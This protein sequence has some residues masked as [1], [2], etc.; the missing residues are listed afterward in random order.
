MMIL[1]KLVD[2]TVLVAEVASYNWNGVIQLGACAEIACAGGR[3]LGQLAAE[4]P[5]LAT[6]IVPE[7]AGGAVNPDHVI[8][9]IPATEAANEVWWDLFRN[10]N[11][12]NNS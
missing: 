4:G 7:P 9:R 5:G 11:V 10:R 1:M 8:R 2:G 12:P 6:H 3:G